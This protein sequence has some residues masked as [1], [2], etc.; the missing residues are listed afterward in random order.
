MRSSK[1]LLYRSRTKDNRV[2]E[3][4]WLLAEAPI[5]ML[6]FSSE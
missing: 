3:L 6:H 2:V 5:E 1:F 4:A